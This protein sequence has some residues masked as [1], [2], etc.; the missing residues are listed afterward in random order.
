MNSTSPSSYSQ[1]DDNDVENAG[2]LTGSESS[3]VASTTIAPET[4]KITAPDIERVRR[5]T[6]VA[7]RGGYSPT[8][9]NSSTMSTST[10][11]DLDARDVHTEPPMKMDRQRR[12]DTIL[13]QKPNITVNPAPVVDNSDQEVCSGGNGNIISRLNALCR[14]R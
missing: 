11:A 13:R 9:N 8:A 6:M 7:V 1:I 14:S 12:R 4:P 5:Q 10:D 3:S 2:S